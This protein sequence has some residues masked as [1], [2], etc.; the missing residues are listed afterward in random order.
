MTTYPW[1]I[2]VRD[3]ALELVGELDD[4]QQ[5]DMVLKFNDVST[6]QLTVDRRSRFAQALVADGAGI[7]VTRD[8]VPILSGGWVDQEHRKDT[9]TNTLT[10]SGVDDT[11]WL[12][13][14]LAHPQP[15]SSAPPY[16]TQSEDFRVAVAS[17]V[18][19]DYVGINEGVTA[20]ASRK[21][22]AVLR[23]PDIFYGATV[24]GRG[25]WQVLL[26]LLQ[27][28]AVAGAVNDL[29]VGFRLVQEGQVLRYKNFIPVDRTAEAVFS[30][31]RGNLASFTFRRSAPEANYVFVG[32]PG[33][34]A[35]RTIYEQPDSDSIAA[36]GRIEGELVDAQSSTTAEELAQSATKA[37][38][39][40]GAKS[41]LSVTPIDTDDLSYGIHYGLG[42]RVTAVLD[43]LGP[44]VEGQIGD[45][46]QDV[47]RECRIQLAPDSSAVTPLV[48]SGG[49]PLRLFDQVGDLSRRLVNQERR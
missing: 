33:T 6:W 25:R 4:Y 11:A 45:A 16:A 10:L 2:H 24:T 9:N 47:L 39:D 49:A 1:T 15:A 42:D 13:R 41:S 22:P 28:M 21:I 3:S 20:V 14:R 23:D 46:I 17:T 30:E 27:E 12:R 34:G 40:H 5:L 44:D 8:G 7:V 19:R 36:W 31:G 26:T 37:L 32:G 29:P 48:G 38:L 43:V 35:A 18:M